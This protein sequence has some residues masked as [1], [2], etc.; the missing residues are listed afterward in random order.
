MFNGRSSFP[1]INQQFFIEPNIY[2]KILPNLKFPLLPLQHSLYAL[3]INNYP[4]QQTRVFGTFIGK[5]LKARIS[6]W[7][8]LFYWNPLLREMPFIPEDYHLFDLPKQPP[9][10]IESCTLASSYRSSSG[11]FA[12]LPNHAEYLQ[13][14]QQ[15]IH[16]EFVTL[17]RLLLLRF[18]LINMINIF[19]RHPVHSAL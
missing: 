14:S 7:R 8:A 16:V 10:D 13:T 11:G 9:G 1:L 6:K 4:S 5:A 19:I 2:I 18:E 15:S 12:A 17:A 3:V